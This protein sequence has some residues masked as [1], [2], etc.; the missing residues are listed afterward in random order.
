[1]SNPWLLGGPPPPLNDAISCQRLPKDQ[2]NFLKEEI[3]RLTEKGV[4]R[5]IEHSRR[6]S[7]A[8][9]EPKTGG[10]R[11]VIVLGAINKH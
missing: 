1:V 6:V 3:V 9:L 8:F 11:L 5:P 7:R 2:D 10:W 4:L